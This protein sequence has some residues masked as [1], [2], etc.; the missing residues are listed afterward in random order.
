MEGLVKYWKEKKIITSK[1]VIKAFMKVPREEFVLSEYKRD[2]YSDYPLP[3]GYG[4]TI[5]QP[6]TVMLMS[7]ALEVKQGNKVLEVGT[8]SG[9]QAAILSCLVGKKGF[10]Y[11]TEIIKELAG[12]A[13]NNLERCGI[14]N[15]KVLN[16]DGSKGYK[17]D[18]PYD[19]IILTAA[20]PKIP[21]HLVKQ[22]KREGIL[23]APVGSLYEQDMLKITKN[24]DRL[25][26]KNLG[27]FVFVRLRGLHGFEDKLT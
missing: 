14:K 21:K 7:Q 23:L 12:F 2:A 15:V 4:Q 17:R 18:M 24:G 16:I 26:T 6:T 1:S 27:S 3:I 9:Y 20:S 5:S 22:L 13:R 25:E 10:V 11:T 8:G 19:R